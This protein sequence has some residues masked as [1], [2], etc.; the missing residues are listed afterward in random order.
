ML[1][2]R[3]ISGLY[4][5]FIFVSAILEMKN[6]KD[7]YEYHVVNII[8]SIVLALFSF[9]GSWTTFVIASIGIFVMYQLVAIFRAIITNYYPWKKQLLEIVVS[10][11]LII[12]ILKIF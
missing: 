3:I 4:A 8:L 5:L 1:V 7:G 10:V 11:T 9:F 2:I 6:K 12:S